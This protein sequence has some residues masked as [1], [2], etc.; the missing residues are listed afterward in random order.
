MSDEQLAS[1]LVGLA[2][3][4]GRMDGLGLRLDSMEAART[5]AR[6]EQDEWKREVRTELAEIVSQTTLT[7]GN[8][9]E[10]QLW[11]AKLNG[12]ASVFA[13][14]QTATATLVVAGVVYFVAWIAT[15]R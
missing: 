13:W 11:R 5:L 2:A 1:I 8:V 10:L 7:N 12:A 15:T 6:V 9:R 4:G 3:L 14:W